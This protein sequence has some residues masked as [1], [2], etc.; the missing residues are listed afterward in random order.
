L[1][2]R[3]SASELFDST[4]TTA[5]ARLSVRHRTN[6]RTHYALRLEERDERDFSS[7]RRS[8]SA[9]L[10]HLLYENLTT[11]FNVDV[12][13]GDVTGGE[14]DSYGAA[15]NFRYRRSI[16][17][18]NLNMNLGLRERVEDDRRDVVFAEVRNES[19]TLSGSTP[20]F[21]E[22]ANV[23]VGSII[24]TDV[25]ETIIYVEGIDYVVLVVGNS[26][27]IAR[28]LLGGIADGQQVLVDYRF[29]PDPPAKTATTTETFGVNLHLWSMLR[30]YYSRSHSEQEFLS[31]IPPD[32][33]TDDTVQRVGG[34]LSWKWSTTKVE[35]EDRD[36][37]SAPTERWLV[38]ETLLF[39]PRRNL[40]VGFAANYSELEFKDT[41]EV[42][43]GSGIAANLGWNVGRTGHLSVNAF[44][45]RTRG[46]TQRT[47]REG[48]SAVYEWRYGAWHPD[49]RYT[50]LD[51][52][53]QFSGES[54]RR[55]TLLFHV[56]RTFR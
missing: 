16:P 48:I 25:T 52:V 38:Q 33:L 42:S 49:V 18:G 50:F 11:S 29:V 21:L 43:K 22:N 41:G 10:S 1:S 39:R 30:L 45:Q 9:G 36:T 4:T 5:S 54:R 40:S 2:F 27:L 28:T 12:S 37:T 24:V 55:T 44:S 35:F 51:E 19:H 31:G 56:K 26:T 15:L 23:D 6:F 32:E 8:L 7:D 46:V 47:V 3:D 34:E 14:I 53:N 17:W 13:E 20:V